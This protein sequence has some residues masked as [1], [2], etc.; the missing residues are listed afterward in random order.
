MSTGCFLHLQHEQS[1]VECSCVVE[2]VMIFVKEITK[3]INIFNIE[4]SKI[5]KNQE[6]QKI[7]GKKLII[8]DRLTIQPIQLQST[9]YPDVAI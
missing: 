8:C 9:L 4:K 6:G 2:D 3:L 1:F 7:R 5:E